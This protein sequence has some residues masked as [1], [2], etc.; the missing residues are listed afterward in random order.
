MDYESTQ[1]FNFKKLSVS[2][3]LKQPL[4]DFL[5]EGLR[6]CGCT[7]L[8]CSDAGEAPFFITYETPLG[9]REGLLAYAFFA[10]SRPTKNRPLDEHRFQIKYGSDAKARLQVEQDPAK[11][12]TSIFVGIDLER[13]LLIGAD[14]VLHDG[15]KMFISVEFKRHDVEEALRKGWHAWERENRTEKEPVET[16]VAVTKARLLDFIR[17]ERTA[18]GL[19]QGH[20]QLL[21]ERALPTQPTPSASAHAL[22]TELGLPEQSLLDLIHQ[23]GRL[24]M[25]VRGWVAEVHLEELFQTVPG[26]DECHRI[27]LDGKPDLSVTYRGRNPVLIECKNVLRTAAADG[28]ARVDFQRTRASKA[29]PCSR[30]YQPSEFSLLA[31]CLHARTENWEFKFAPTATLPPHKTC[32]GRLQSSLKVNE[33]WYQEPEAALDFVSSTR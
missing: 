19:D 20:R 12:V 31:A 23:T 7:V 33:A 16:L 21:A 27:D 28:S 4:L 24:K 11:L 26:V 22:I 6:A 17:F 32:I 10:N 18:V 8:F 3:R 1:L 2:R 30:Y 14:P 9:E 25:A 15:T 13:G 29:D 5:L